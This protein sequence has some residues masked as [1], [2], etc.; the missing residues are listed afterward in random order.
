MSSTACNTF[1]SQRVRHHEWMDAPDADPVEIERSLR[2]IRRI[3]RALGYTRATLKHLEHFSQ[4]WKPGQR[5]TMIDFATGSADVPHAVL[6]W[7]DRRG[8][9]VRIVGIDFHGAT[10]RL[11]ATSVGNERLRIVQADALNLPFAANSFDY[12]LCSMFLHHLSEDQAVAVLSA[13]SRIARRGIIAADLLRERPAYNWIYLMTLFS[14]PMIRHD[15]RVSV[16][17]AFSPDEARALRDR[18]KLD[19]TKYYRHFAHRFVLAGGEGV[20]VTRR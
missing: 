8:F 14:R 6:R 20:S 7:A 2:F 1:L 15:A 9:D 5:I 16:L 18:A 12:A 4:S 19:F 13:M 11:A 17:Q 3:N 10:A